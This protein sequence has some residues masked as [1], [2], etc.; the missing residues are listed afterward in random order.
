MNIDRDDPR[1]TAFVLGELDSTEHALVEAYLIDSADCREAVEEIRLT[2]RWLSEQLLAESRAHHQVE[3]AG[4]N[5]HHAAGEIVAK[6]D[7]PPRRGWGRPAIRKGSIAAAVLALVGLAVLPFVR[8]NVQPRPEVEHV[9]QLKGRKRAIEDQTNRDFARFGDAAPGPGAA[10]LAPR[11]AAPAPKRIRAAGDRGE[12]ASRSFGLS[13]GA[14][15]EPA[16]EPANSAFE[17]VDA[18]GVARGGQL[19]GM[20]GG[21]NGNMQHADGRQETRGARGADLRPADAGGTTVCYGD[22]STTV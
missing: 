19:G 20:G 22:G 10:P 12:E 11:V 14:P 7:A 21:A 5:N 8:V 13:Q 1:L 15:S 4:I 18:A 17:E 16:S 9:F 6:L 3:Q 2:T